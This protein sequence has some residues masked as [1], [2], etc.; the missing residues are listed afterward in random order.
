MHF[1]NW[2]KF[3]QESQTIKEEALLVEWYIPLPTL[4]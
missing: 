1:D 2:D 4:A 3:S